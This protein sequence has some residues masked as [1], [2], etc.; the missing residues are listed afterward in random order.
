MSAK[1]LLG[2]DIGSSSIKIV[3]LRIMGGEVM[4]ETYGEISN[5]P[6]ADKDLGGIARPGKD[7]L[8]E[9]L[10]DLVHEIDA[11]SRR[12]GVAIP[13]NE[14]LMSQVDLPKRDKEQ[15]DKIIPAE[16]QRFIPVPVN[17]IMLDWYAIPEPETY[18]FDAMKPKQMTEAQFQ[19][20]MIIGVNKKTAQSFTSAMAESGF[21]CEFFEIEIFSALRASMHAKKEPTLLLDLGASST[22]AAIASEHWVLLAGRLIPVGG[23]FITEE[24]RHAQNID[25]PAAERL[26]CEQG[27][28]PGSTVAPIIEKSIAPVWSYIEQVMDELKK[29]NQRSVE[30]VL[31]CG[32][33]AYMPGVREYIQ[34][35]MSLPVEVMHGFSRTKGPMVLEDIIELD[36]PRYA[37]A[38]GLALRGI[39]R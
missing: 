23:A 14:T 25:F 34:K 3:Q 27:L 21:S 30:H 31:L 24:I 19:K 36:G 26:K 29:K 7:K 33:G 28:A 1:Y 4:L 12:S 17:E 8:S 11:R 2:I 13:F 37:I 15:M 16:A 20:I 6:Y 9:E 10:S 18:A 32:G 22:K 39:G 5:A 35:K 38:A